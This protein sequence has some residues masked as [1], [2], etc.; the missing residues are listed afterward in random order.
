MEIL[1]LSHSY[2]WIGDDWHIAAT[3]QENESYLGSK[4]IAINGTTIDEVF[5]LCKSIMSLENNQWAKENFSN[6]VL[7]KE[8]LEFIGVVKKEEPII[9]TV[10]NT[11]NTQTDIKI[12]PLTKDESFNDDDI[13]WFKSDAVPITRS[14]DI[15][16]GLPLDENTFFI[17]YNACREDPNL[18][19]SDFR[20]MMKE[21]ITQGEYSTLVIDL[22]Y[23]SGGN[24]SIMI[25]LLANLRGL[26]N[27]GDIKV[28]TLI[29]KATF[30]SGLRNSIDT[31]DLLKHLQIMQVE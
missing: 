28:Y 3:N 6:W 21:E 15:C 25:P 14:K 11:Q 4:L 20:I 27:N 12:I 1:A 22:R 31:V 5:E 13:I 2:Y 16:R 19:M 7:Y 24:S 23:N 26:Q 29:G 30:S 9:F 18:P 17:Q 8:A 10:E